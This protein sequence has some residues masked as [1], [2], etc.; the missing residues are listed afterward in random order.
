MTNDEA[1]HRLD[2]HQIL[3]ALISI[4]QGHKFQEWLLVQGERL[5]GQ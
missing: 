4:T 5:S 3:H 1:P 2:M